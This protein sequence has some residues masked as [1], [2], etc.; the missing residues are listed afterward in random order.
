MKFNF[1]KNLPTILSVLGVV[2]AGAVG[3][4]AAVAQHKVEEEL[5]TKNLCSQIKADR[6]EYAKTYAKHYWPTALVFA[7]TAGCIIGS[8][9]LNQK[10]YAQLMRAYGTLGAGFAAYRGAVVKEYGD[11]KDKEFLEAAEKE[12]LCTC[13]NYICNSS[14]VTNA[15]PDD[16]K[17][18]YEPVTRQYFQKRERDV[19][20]AEYLFNRDFCIGS[21]MNVSRL[22]EYLGIVPTHESDIRGWSMEYGYMWVDI[23]HRKMKH[24]HNGEPCFEICYTFLPEKNFEEYYSEDGGIYDDIVVSDSCSGEEL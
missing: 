19:I 22:C 24:L 4:S 9:K 13:D 14:D 8:N 10:Q 20:H 15:I 23:S 6:K 2:G 21:A 3:V 5:K 1:K 18:F 16:V 7:G 12:C 11:E 17:W